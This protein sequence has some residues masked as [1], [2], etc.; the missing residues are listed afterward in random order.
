MHLLRHF[1]MEPIYALQTP[2]RTVYKTAR[3]VSKSTGLAASRIMKSAVIPHFSSL[4][5]AP[6]YIQTTRFST[7]V[8]RPM[9]KTSPIRSLLIDGSGV[10][11]NVLQLQMANGSVQHFSFAFHDAERIRGVTCDQVDLDECSV[12]STPI[13]TAKGNVPLGDLK[14][15]DHVYGYDENGIR[16]DDRVVKCMYHN[17]R[18]CYRITCA[19]GST[20]DIT[21]KSWIA[22]TAGWKR[23]ET[24]IGEAHAAIADARTRTNGTRNNDGGCLH[25]DAENNPGI[26]AISEQPRL[27]SAR[28]QL[29]Q[30]PNIIRVRSSSSAQ[31]SEFRIR[32]MAQSLE[33]VELSGA[34][35]YRILVS[36]R[37]QE[38]RHA[39][40]AGQTDV[41]GDRLVVPGR[42]EP[43]PAENDGGVPHGRILERG[44]RADRNLDD[45]KDGH[46]VSRAPDEA[47]ASARA[48]LDD[49]ANR[50]LDTEANGEDQAICPSEHGLQVRDAAGSSTELPPLRSSGSGT[51]LQAA[52]GDA[53]DVRE[54]GVHT[55]LPYGRENEVCGCTGKPGKEAGDS[56]RDVCCGRG[57][58]ARSRRKEG[59]EVEGGQPVGCTPDQATTLA[60]GAGGAEAAPVDV[61]GV[62]ADEPAGHDG[63]QDEILPRVQGDRDV[64]PEGR[65]RE[66]APATSEIVS[67]EYVGEH[68]VYDIETEKYH[69]YYAGGIAVHNCQDLNPDFIDVIESTMDASDWA[70]RRY[71]GTPKTSDNLLQTLFDDSSAAEWVTPCA[72]CNRDNIATTAHHLMDMI[73]EKGP[74]CYKCG[75]LLDP[76][77]GHFEHERPELRV[78]FA[79][80]HVPQAIMPFHYANPDKWLELYTAKT[81]M[82]PVRFLNEKCGESCDVMATL[83]SKPDL[84]K[85]SVLPWRNTDN[86]DK[87]LTKL[88]KQYPQLTL[89][90]DWGGYGAE[91]VSYTAFV[92]LGHH[93][94]GKIDVLR[95]RRLVQTTG[96]DYE[97][98]RII[99]MAS[100]GHIYRMGHDYNGA[101]ATRETLLIHA[102]FP[103]EGI[104]PLAYTGNNT[105]A[106]A[107]YQPPGG[108]VARGYYRVDKPRA[109][110]LV[111]ECI[112]KGL[113]RFP[114]FDSWNIREGDV[115]SLADDFLAVAE[116]HVELDRASSVIVIRKKPGRCD[117]VLHALVYGALAHWQ[118]EQ[119]YPDIAFAAG[120]AVTPAQQEQMTPSAPIDWGP[121]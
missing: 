86:D 15:G 52:E 59:G 28:V 30:A 12:Y 34:L 60:Q 44:V 114:M 5:V 8:L 51:P 104:V 61:P 50:R 79:G 42:R 72:G 78:R 36:S 101:G 97:V 32:D 58:A 11:D 7:L 21:S 68:P 53:P 99:E 24:I 102:G 118:T 108:V 14:V 95:M 63:R 17:V 13:E 26:A 27:G 110:M 65:E 20:V 45:K 6:L 18:D 23:V 31:I 113:I 54:A 88:V 49:P 80:Y 9:L 103:L 75:K 105:Q 112:K 67:I 109:V 116:D 10:L 93:T 35:A 29:S 55:D 91:G 33:H 48:V 77:T 83:I 39:G 100:R 82:S 46:R 38:T 81:K 90:V 3:Q 106:I 37:W 111:A 98:K 107:N 2:R 47:E 40:V 84:V 41:G 57:E 119:R 73:Q 64:A 1:V 121:I 96:N 22:T 85:A 89:G 87:E 94:D 117:D 70:V 115:Q 25:R 92:L 62:R 69:T 56:E 74:S 66:T 16:H 43:D 76:A 4:Y 120:I 19:D 71:F